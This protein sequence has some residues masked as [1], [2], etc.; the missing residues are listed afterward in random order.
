MLIFTEIRILDLY[1]SVKEYVVIKYEEGYLSWVGIDVGIVRNI[2]VGFI[3]DFLSFVKEVY[4]Y[5]I[6]SKVF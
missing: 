3:Y 1:S 2:C 5:I 6:I 4:K